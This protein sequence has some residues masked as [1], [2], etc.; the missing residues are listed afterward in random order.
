MAISNSKRKAGKRLLC[1]ALCLTLLSCLIVPLTKPAEADEISMIIVSPDSQEEVMPEETSEGLNEEAQEPE[2]EQKPASNVMPAQTQEPAAEVATVQAQEPEPEI[3]EGEQLL[4]DEKEPEY[5]G[6]ELHVRMSE[7]NKQSWL[8]K[9]DLEGIKIKLER[10]EPVEVPEDSEEPHDLEDD[11]IAVKY[12][13]GDKNGKDVLFE[14]DKDGLAIIALDAEDDGLILEYGQKYRLVFSEDI[15]SIAGD[16]EGELANILPKERTLEFILVKEKADAEEEPD[17]ADHGKT[18]FHFV[19]AEENKVEETPADSTSVIAAD[20]S[21]PAT[22]VEDTESTETEAPELGKA[23]EEPKSDDVKFDADSV[24]SSKEISYLWKSDRETASQVQTGEENWNTGAVY[25]EPCGKYAYR[26]CVKPA[27]SGMTNLVLYDFLEAFTPD[28]NE[29]WKGSFEGIDL[30]AAEERDVVPTVY[31]SESENPGKLHEDESWKM[32]FSG[33]DSAAVKSLAFDFG[34]QVIAQKSVVSVVIKMAAPAD[35]SPLNAYNRFTAAYNRIDADAETV[36][37][38]RE[39]VD[40]N[41]TIVSMD[42]DISDTVSLNLISE[43]EREPNNW[44]ERPNSI[45]AYILQDGVRFGDPVKITAE[46]NW[47]AS[48]EALPRFDENGHAYVY[49]IE[50]DAVPGYTASVAGYTITN[51]FTQTSQIILGSTVSGNMA[52]VDKYV[53]YTITMQDPNNSEFVVQVDWSGADEAQDPV[54]NPASSYSTSE[55]MEANTNEWHSNENGV[56]TKT[57][58]LKHGQT[59]MIDGVPTGVIYMISV[60][61]ED[62]GTRWNLTEDGTSQSDIIST[63]SEGTLD[64]NANVDFTLSREVLIP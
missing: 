31:Y 59:I 27:V 7:N 29:S 22:H 19:E 58:Y 61:A 47:Q 54:A 20:D 18:E 15:I 39:E 60:S 35:I 28:D 41:V 34:E 5:Q 48:V 30:T 10:Y 44:K 36:G 56:L 24:K 8:D 46:N 52:S 53:A 62:Y 12:L 33:V 1:F 6:F 2:E 50:A 63:T 42:A 37:D 17:I 55:I 32:Y 43:W 49:T 45:T 9:K 3:V 57:V 38:E 40:S 21:D 11:W 4:E 26:L 64:Q 25:V 23:A 14:T 16:E 13:A 51:H